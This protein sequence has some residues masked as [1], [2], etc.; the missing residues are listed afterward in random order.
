MLL[1]LVPKVR[2]PDLRLSALQGVVGCKE[3]HGCRPVMDG[4]SVGPPVTRLSRWGLARVS[5][6]SGRTGNAWRSGSD[7]VSTVRPSGLCGAPRET[8]PSVLQ[9]KG[10]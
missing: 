2:N 1:L 10:P 9:E 5:M 4:G 7:P 8:R 3:L 6:A